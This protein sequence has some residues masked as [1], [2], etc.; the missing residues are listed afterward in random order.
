LNASATISRALAH[1]RRSHRALAVVTDYTGLVTALRQRIAELGTHMEAV[2]EVAGLP[3]RYT[4]KLMSENNHTSLGRVSLGPLLGALASKLVVVP[5][6][7][8][9]ARVRHRLL[10]RDA[11][12]R[13]PSLLAGSAVG[14]LGGRENGGTESSPPR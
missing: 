8:A 1:E 9:L 6:Q 12:G 3:L 13:G 2:D 5:D 10:A 11:C 4:S 14:L 7:D